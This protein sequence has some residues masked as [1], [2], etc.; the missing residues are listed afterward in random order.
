[1]RYEAFEPA[2][3]SVLRYR[4]VLRVSHLRRQHVIITSQTLSFTC[5]GFRCEAA[6]GL[7]SFRTYT[8]LEE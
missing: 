2:D 5:M 8:T 4:Y 1:M 7:L 6:A 3:I